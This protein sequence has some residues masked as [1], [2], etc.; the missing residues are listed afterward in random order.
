MRVILVDDEPLSLEL[1][2]IECG[3]MPG[4][5]VVGFFDN[6]IDALEFARKNPVDFALLDIDMPEMTGIELARKLRSVRPGMI[7]IF[8][9]AHP[10][11]AADAI[12][13]K[14]DFVV[15]KPYEREDILDA[16]ERARLLSERQKKRVRFRTFGHFDMFVEGRLVNFKSAKAK[17]LLALCVSRMGGE[18]TIYEM[19]NVLWSGTGDQG[20]GYRTTIKAL[21]D[22]LKEVDADGILRRKR[23]V[24]SLNTDEFDCDL[25]DFKAG[26]A[27]ALN[28]FHGEFMQQYLWA[29]PMAAELTAEKGQK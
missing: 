2:K 26:K 9:T 28:A 15:F 16:L 12:H 25:L 24:L 4:F 3:N 29:Q 19:V 6:P 10:E 18:V 21:S 7:V 5:D 1:F 17:E 20:L 11:Y 23:S 27:S 8:V 22:T 13:A 14:A